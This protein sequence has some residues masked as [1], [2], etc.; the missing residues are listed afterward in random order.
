MNV[1]KP[2]KCVT[3]E[4]HQRKALLAGVIWKFQL[5]TVCDAVATFQRHNPRDKRVAR[6]WA[7]R[8][9]ICIIRVVK[10]L[11]RS[12]TNSQLLFAGSHFFF[13][14]PL[15]RGISDSPEFRPTVFTIPRISII[16][17]RTLKKLIRFER[18]T[19]RHWRSDQNDFNSDFSIN[20]NYF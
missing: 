7:D 6:A 2:A 4:M 11:S 1:F 10:Q 20:L 16:S 8:R 19:L 13:F 5:S 12:T 17:R 15:C 3:S 18:L 14:L 9:V